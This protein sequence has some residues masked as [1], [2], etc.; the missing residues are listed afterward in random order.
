VVRNFLTTRPPLDRPLEIPR[1]FTRD[2]PDAMNPEIDSFIIYDNVRLTQS[3]RF[4]R[5]SQQFFLIL[6]LSS[7]ACEGTCVLLQSTGSATVKKAVDLKL[8]VFFPRNFVKLLENRKKYCN[9]NII[10]T[11]NNSIANKVEIIIKR[12]YSY[13]FL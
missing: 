12:M 9:C 4:L 13:F 2:P 5:Y 7:T 10:H 1:V 8:K 6:A 3:S 11:E